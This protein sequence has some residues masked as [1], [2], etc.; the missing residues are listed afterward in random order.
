MKKTR[1]LGALGAVLSLSLALAACS[2]GDGGSGGDETAAASGGTCDEL[3]VWAWDPAFNIYALQEAEKVYQA[4]H[5]DFKLN[6]VETPWDD[7]QTKLTT[8]AQSGETDQLPDI[9]LM[10]NNAF[11]KNVINYPDIFADFAD[12]T[13]DFSE[14]PESVVSYSTV[15]DTNYGVPFDNGTAIGAY[16]TDILEQ[17]GY[18][19]DDFTD[20]TWDEFL[21]IGEDVL[22]KTG[23]PMLTGQAGSSD[24]IMMMLQSAGA[25]MFDDEG[26]P[27]ITDNEA[28]LAAIDMY[29]K[30]VKSGVYVEVNSWDEYINTIVNSNTASV[31][32][33]VWISGSI[34]SAADQSGKWA[35][36]NVPKLEGVKGAT[37]YTANGGSSWATSAGPNSQC[38]DDFLAATFAGSTAFYDTILPA[39]GAL[40]NWLPAGDSDVYSQ[41][42][43][44]FGGQPIYADVLKFAA[45]VPSNNTGAYYYEGRDAVSVAITNIMNGA[46]PKTALAEAQSTVEFAMG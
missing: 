46:D 18:T 32:N 22:A 7:L 3:T 4:D 12:S 6:I 20:I 29:Q 45:K 33:G 2:G 27:T 11:Q 31:I 43:E 8:L 14:F 23:K 30:L 40:A 21:T 15:D 41:P 1:T 9:F 26:N 38:A 37:N 24:T 28:L 17:A 34:Q 16:R 19:V 42:Q 5:P 25:S 44:F 36:T 35:V 39:S 13:V 10:Q